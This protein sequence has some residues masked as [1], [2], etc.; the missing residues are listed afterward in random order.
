MAII[1]AEKLVTIDL[2]KKPKDKV[3]LIATAGRHKRL[4]TLKS[5]SLF[6][7]YTDKGIVKSIGINVTIAMRVIPYRPTV[8]PKISNMILH[9]R[10]E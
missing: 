5:T 9:G 1:Q 6:A 2:I 4:I 7:R 3:I 8:G 10:C